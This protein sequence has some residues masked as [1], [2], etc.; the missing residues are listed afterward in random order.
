MESV[1]AHTS[2]DLM[3]LL[4]TGVESCPVICHCSSLVHVKCS[5]SHGLGFVF[6]YLVSYLSLRFPFYYVCLFRSLHSVSIPPQ[7]FDCPHASSPRFWLRQSVQPS[8]FLFASCLNFSIVCAPFFPCCLA[9][10]MLSHPRTPP[11]PTFI[12]FNSSVQCHPACYCS[13]LFPFFFTHNTTLLLIELYL[14]HVCASCL[15]SKCLSL[16]NACSMCFDSIASA[17]AL[18]TTLLVFVLVLVSVIVSSLPV[19]GCHFLSSCS[20]SIRTSFIILFATSFHSS[21]TPS[22]PA[23]VT[24]IVQLLSHAICAVCSSFSYVQNFQATTCPLAFL[25]TFSSFALSNLACACILL[26]VF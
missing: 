9:L 19:K 16:L 20:P 22:S 11:F 8:C 12:H 18:L 3:W 15:R 5:S 26:F 23:F 14:S 6:L 21:A 2:V 1:N 4:A 7:V 10:G 24:F 25:P 17:C 13:H